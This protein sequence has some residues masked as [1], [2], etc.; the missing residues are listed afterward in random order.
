MQ[1]SVIP[2]DTKLQRALES[3]RKGKQ[4]LTPATDA[5]DH[6]AAAQQVE[7][8]PEEILPDRS[9]GNISAHGSRGRA[10][11]EASLIGA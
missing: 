9:R 10:S 2:A 8:A 4:K 1:E 7:P 3:G 5:G 6:D 11:T